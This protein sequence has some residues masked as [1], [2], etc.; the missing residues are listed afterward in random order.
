MTQTES[1]YVNPTWN[2]FNTYLHIFDS[3]IMVNDFDK[4]ATLLL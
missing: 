1:I 3:F 2:Q 4:L